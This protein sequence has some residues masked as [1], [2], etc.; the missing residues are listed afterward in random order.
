MTH[1][2]TPDGHPQVQ[3]FAL[4]ARSSNWSRKLLYTTKEFPTSGTAKEKSM[5]PRGPAFLGLDFDALT[6][7]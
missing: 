6:G 2:P 5:W 3:R 7:H 4:P 1:D